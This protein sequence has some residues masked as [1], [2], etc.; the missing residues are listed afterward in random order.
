MARNYDEEYKKFHKSKKS[1]KARASRNKARRKAIRNGT[2][3][4]GDS[5]EVHHSKPHAK[6]KTKVVSRK[7]NRRIGKPGRKKRRG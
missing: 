5:K 4:K 7:T 2:V 6:G 1:K 3:K